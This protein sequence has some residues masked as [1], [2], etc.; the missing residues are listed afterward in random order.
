MYLD[1]VIYSFSFFLFLQVFFSEIMSPYVNQTIPEFRELPASTSA[2]AALV[3]GSEVC[4]TMQPGGPCQAKR[5]NLK[6]T[7]K[8]QNKEYSNVSHS[9]S[10]ENNKTPL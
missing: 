8:H 7:L 9:K 5:Y 6:R 1:K 3:L 2:S 4:T 10:N